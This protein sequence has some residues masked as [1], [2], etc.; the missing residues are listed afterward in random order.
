MAAVIRATANVGK[1]EVCMDVR[2]TWGAVVVQSLPVLFHGLKGSQRR[3]LV[4]RRCN[5]CGNVQMYADVPAV[6]DGMSMR[7]QSGTEIKDIFTDKTVA[8][9]FET[10]IVDDC[11]PDEGEL[12]YS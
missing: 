9:T 12:I 4:A 2:H 10:K 1:C 8:S 3:P 7:W 11:C 6:D 5:K